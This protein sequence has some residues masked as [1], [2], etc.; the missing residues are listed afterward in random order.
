MEKI[1]HHQADHAGSSYPSQ[2]YDS[3]KSYVTKITLPCMNYWLSTD[4]TLSHWNT[5]MTAWAG[6]S[7]HG[8]FVDGFILQLA[9]SPVYKRKDMTG[10]VSISELEQKVD[11][12]SDGSWDPEVKK[13]LQAKISKVFTILE[14]RTYVIRARHLTILIAHV[15]SKVNLHAV[16]HWRDYEVQTWVPPM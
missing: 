3:S 13:W 12:L 7:V 9:V 11:N 15:M 1:K 8:V 16:A 10:N 14:P 6:I 4:M 2:W 5:G